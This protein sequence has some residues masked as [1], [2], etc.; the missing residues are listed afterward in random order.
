MFVSA[1]GGMFVRT[2]GGMFV[3]T[4]DGGLFVT[5]W[6]LLLCCVLELEVEM[7]LVK[8]KDDEM[9]H[10]RPALAGAR[11]ARVAVSA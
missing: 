4:T 6:Q 9:L 1:N 11:S 5:S 7:V 3:G 8:L 10:G 2:E